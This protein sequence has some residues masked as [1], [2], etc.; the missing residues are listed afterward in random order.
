MNKNEI[1][2]GI[3][4]SLY[5]NHPNYHNHM[6]TVLQKLL[7]GVKVKAKTK[8]AQFQIYGFAW[9]SKNIENIILY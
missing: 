9:C 2:V 1:S 4:G 5:E 3:D 8:N 7:P 6:T